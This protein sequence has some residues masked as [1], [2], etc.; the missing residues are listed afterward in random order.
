MTVERI[1]ALFGKLRSEGKT[2]LI[3]YLTV[4]EPS[5]PET[6]ALARAALAA[7]A[8]LL[9]LGV[10]F[11][12]P[13]ADGPVIAAASYRAIH[14]GGSLRAALEVASELRQSSDAPLVLFT[15]YNP[16]QTFGDTRFP[17]AAIEAGADGALIVDLPPEEGA[18]LRDAAEKERLAL[19]P[20]IA[21]TTSR[22]REAGIFAR[23]RGFIYYVSVT[24]VTGT[25][26]APLSQ[27]GKAAKGLSQRSGLPVVV[28]FGIRTPEDART[29][30]R[31]G[32]DG[33]VVGTEVIRV[34][35]E[36]AD[37]AGRVAAVSRLVADLRA[38]LDRG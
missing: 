34:I 21:P 24:G 8:D 7:G 37:A 2:A 29:V 16:V 12:D 36:A 14:Q 31:E 33:V 4:G 25:K 35:G 13:T 3:A 6:L 11:S 5:V 19:I 32:A 1:E 9:E 30:A 28:G 17:T 27:A 18:E 38:G 20:L 10:P 26:A 22:Q 15:Y 23:A